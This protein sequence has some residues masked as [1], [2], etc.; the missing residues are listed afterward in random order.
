MSDFENILTYI[1]YSLFQ[2]TQQPITI[3]LPTQ[4]QPVQGVTTVK[5]VNPVISK[6][7]LSGSQATVTTS[8]ASLQPLRVTQYAYTQTGE[9]IAIQGLDPGQIKPGSTIQL[10][11][12][13]GGTQT[14]QLQGL[15]GLTT[16]D[17]SKLTVLQELPEVGK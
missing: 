5:Y 6:A 11:C 10:Q 15:Q 8:T 3:Q 1:S 9:R 16:V 2:A 12:K 17:P 7:T 4:P 13:G 14:L